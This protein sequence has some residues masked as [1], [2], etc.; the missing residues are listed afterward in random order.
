[1]LVWPTSPPK[2]P[3][4]IAKW[5]WRGGKA[6]GVHSTPSSPYSSSLTLSS[7]LVLLLSSSSSPS[8]SL[9]SPKRR[10]RG[11]ADKSG[12]IFP[13]DDC[14]RG[15]S[16]SRAAFQSIRTVDDEDCIREQRRT[17]RRIFSFGYA[18]T[19][20][21]WRLRRSCTSNSAATSVKSEKINR[22]ISRRNGILQR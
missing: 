12:T 22:V 3:R 1:M 15:R 17:R 11:T 4:G 21:C 16:H 13:P 19:V 5:R 10:W 2:R 18:T 6:T 7:L 14:H 9:Y 20:R 8:P